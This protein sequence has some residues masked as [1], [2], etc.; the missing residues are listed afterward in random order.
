MIARICTNGE[1][2]KPTILKNKKSNKQFQ[3]TSLLEEKVY[4]YVKEGMYNTVNNI[5]GTAYQSREIK[6]DYF[7]VD[8]PFSRSKRF[9]IYDK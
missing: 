9:T 4:S 6:S 8:V 7:L 5:N 2:I 1:L 3:K